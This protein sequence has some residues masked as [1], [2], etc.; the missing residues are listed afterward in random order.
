MSNS[1]PLI[2]QTISHY[3]IV[4]KLG[5]GGMGVVYKAEDVRLKRFVALKFLPHET[6]QSRT[7]L[8]RFR[9]EAEASSALNH[10][11]I[12]SIYDIGAQNGEHFIV[13]EFLD[14]QTLKHY[15]AGQPLPIDQVLELAIQI[16]GALDAAHSKGIIHRDIKPANLF[17]TARG[18]AKVLDFGLAKLVHGN[19]APDGMGFASVVTETADH[20]LTAPGAAVGTVAFMSP[21]QVR[22]EELDTRT[23]L[24]SFGLVLYEMATGHPAFRGKTSGI[25][26]EAILNRS[27]V[28][29]ADLNPQVPPKLKEI[30]NK[31][32]EKDR[33]LRYQNA[34]DIRSDLKRLKRDT[35]SANSSGPINGT[36]V[37]AAGG[38]ATSYRITAVS[39]LVLL[40]GSAV[41][42]YFHSHRALKLTAKDTI[43]LGDF[44]NTTG[45]SV[46]D[47]TLRQ[48]LAVQLE[49]SPF[50][51]LLP[52]ERVQQ[53]IRLMGQPAGAKL[54]N[55]TAKEVCQRTGGIALIS[56]SIASL[57]T[58]YVLDIRAVNCANG[59][60]LAEEQIQGPGKEHVLK[61][62]GEAAAKLRTNLG[63]SSLTVSKFAI[64]LEE[65][66]TPS[67][68][69]LQA[70]SLGEK[71][72]IGNNDPAAAVAFFQRAV[73][74]DP[75]FAMAYAALGTC[76]SSLAERSLAAE[77]TLKAYQARERVS[78]REKLYIEAH[79]YDF[80]VGDLEKARQAYEIW[81]ATYPRDDVPPNNLSGIYRDLG[82]YD[83]SLAQ[84]RNYFRLNPSTSL[85]YANLMFAYLRL[86]RL[87][88]AGATAKEAQVKKLDSPYLHVYLYVLAFLQ[89]D[90]A[91]MSEQITW[92]TGKPGV[93]DLML[94]LEA[95]VYAYSGQ[96][97]KAR[98]LS[99]N[100]VAAAERAQEKETAASYE[101]NAAI[102]E[103]LFGN[104]VE[105]RRRAKAGLALSSGRDEQASAALAMSLAG[106]ADD[107]KRLTLDLAK[108][109]PEDTIV[110][111]N[112]LPT[113][114]A[115]LALSRNDASK[116]IEFLRTSSPY[117]LGMTGSLYSVYV[118]GTA[119]LATGRWP[120][121]RAEFQKILDYRS[122]VLTVPIG[123]L[124]HL[125][126][127]RAYAFQGDE[128]RGRAAYQDFFTL[129]KDADPDIPILKQAK[130]AYAKLR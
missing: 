7:A 38:T 73:S 57:G 72:M 59:D 52:D 49:Q 81:A 45:D 86:N 123:A 71:T 17:V 18:Q 64:P 112:Y 89:N 122:V 60:L 55:E 34:S 110:Q 67:L 99:K 58:Q 33:R 32:L 36:N 82:Q 22:G 25:I 54:T 74:L 15:V 103:A 24:F 127:A 16:T 51:S 120:E 66:T 30:I 40:A 126:L 1:A 114:Q 43:V 116:A 2:G 3:R 97:Q 101:M 94:E 37:A 77:S 21:E 48:G 5:G 88:E 95:E 91:G 119:F 111:F 9:R 23:D 65:A 4:E 47:G 90:K 107:A 104:P 121:A 100:A 62:L 44:V 11:N 13:M 68:E 108:N 115:Q 118:R 19:D 78:Q 69:A 46:F 28:P 128:P 53:T 75:N 42:L 12:C 6:S 8:E 109:F 14:G 56:G 39:I 63:E 35:E 93:E 26:T 129:W 41:A 96:L 76:Y 79:Y 10:P 117:D 102:R 92:S 20:L 106:D 61:M 50:L 105:A 85:S 31:A 83:K 29:V 27:P 113:I 125:G 80:V 130:T 124:A 70:Y 98:E 84:A 87:G